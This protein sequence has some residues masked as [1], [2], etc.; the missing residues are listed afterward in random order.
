M[1]EKPGKV[2]QKRFVR[3]I[4]AM[5]GQNDPT[6]SLISQMISLWKDTTLF[7]VLSFTDALG[8]AQAAIAQP[9]KKAARTVKPAFLVIGFS[10]RNV[11]M[12]MMNILLLVI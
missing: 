6:A 8:G 11:D 12:D 5:L 10:L 7:S 2:I 1:N 9:A 3:I 4:R